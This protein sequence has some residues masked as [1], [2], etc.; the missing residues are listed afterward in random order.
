M[1]FTSV[2]EDDFIVI[3][4]KYLVLQRERY[5]VYIQAFRKYISLNQTSPSTNE[6]SKIKTVFWGPFFSQTFLRP[7]KENNRD[8]DAKEDWLWS[9][10]Q[11]P[12]Y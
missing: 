5:M 4:Y 8:G 10:D 6:R 12:T 3:Y 2:H 7:S 11:S 9:N 1:F